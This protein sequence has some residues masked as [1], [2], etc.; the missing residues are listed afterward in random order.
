VEIVAPDAETVPPDASGVAALAAIE[1][2]VVPTTIAAAAATA[3]RTMGLTCIFLLQENEREGSLIDSI[4]G[5][6][7]VRHQ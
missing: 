2:D 5:R 3:M 4:V 1:D 6:G 7:G